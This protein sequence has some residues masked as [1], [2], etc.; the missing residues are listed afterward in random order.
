MVFI[1]YRKT[2]MHVRNAMHRRKQNKTKFKI[3][4]CNF[5]LVAVVAAHRSRPDHAT[6]NTCAYSAAKKNSIKTY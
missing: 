5:R 6:V 3:V 4:V 2:L 1:N